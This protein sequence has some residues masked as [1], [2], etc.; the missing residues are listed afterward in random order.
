VENDME[1]IEK[2]FGEAQQALL[3][4]FK[5]DM[6]DAADVVLDSLYTD[7]SNYATTDA[8]TNYHQYLKDQFSESLTK[9]ISSEYG[10]YSWAHHIRMRLLKDHK[11]VLQNK[12]VEDLQ[13]KI[14]SLE[15]HIEQMRKRR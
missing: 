12:I 9:E 7:V 2:K 3:E 14:K 1:D 6:K 11:D 8:H 13:E 5:K 10:H 4:R 15:E